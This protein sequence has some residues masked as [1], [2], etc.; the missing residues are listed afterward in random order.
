M[1]KKLLIGLMLAAMCL[2]SS[3]ETCPVC[4]MNGYWTG[5][6]QYTWGRTFY[7]YKCP[8]EHFWWVRQ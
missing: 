4:D 8:A 7:G 5:K 6:T 1:I 2:F 3:M